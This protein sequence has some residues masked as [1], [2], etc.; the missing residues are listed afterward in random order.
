MKK[1]WPIPRYLSMGLSM[2]IHAICES[3]QNVALKPS[4]ISGFFLAKAYIIKMIII[5]IILIVK[6]T[7]FPIYAMNAA[8]LASFECLQLILPRVD[9]DYQ[10]FVI[11]YCQHL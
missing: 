8:K 3:H 1:T 2:L 5:L 6:Q 11:F 10:Y 4:K 9:V 7:H